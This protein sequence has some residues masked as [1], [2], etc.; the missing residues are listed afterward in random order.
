MRCRL[1]NAWK[2]LEQAVAHQASQQ[3]VWQRRQT[4]YLLLNQIR[5]Q[6][7]AGPAFRAQSANLAQLV[8]D[9]A[10]AGE[11][12]QTLQ[13]LKPAGGAQRRA[14]APVSMPMPPAKPGQSKRMRRRR[15]IPR[16]RAVGGDG[17]S[18]KFASW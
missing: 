15:P 17:Q 18:S 16:R 2:K 10:G 9:L 1:S 6:V 14:I 12:L 13:S 5:Q 4:A 3:T 11:S 7:A 8:G